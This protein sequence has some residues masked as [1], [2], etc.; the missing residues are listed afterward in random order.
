MTILPVCVALK[1][2]YI[3]FYLLFFVFGFYFFYLFMDHSARSDADAAVALFC[4]R[5]QQKSPI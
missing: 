1:R 3:I 2:W 5:Y 4:E